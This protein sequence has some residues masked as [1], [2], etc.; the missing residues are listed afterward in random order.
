MKIFSFILAGLVSAICLEAGDIQKKHSEGLTIHEWGTFTSVQGSNGGL[1]AWNPF[2]TDA[3]PSFVYDRTRPLSNDPTDTDADGISRRF[4]AKAQTI[5]LQRMETPVIYAYSDEAMELDVRVGFP[6]GQITEWYP[7]VSG[8]GPTS[9]LNEMVPSTRKS[10]VEWNNIQIEPLSSD[11]EE[12]IPREEDANHY[13]EARAVDANLLTAQK[14]LTKKFQPETERFL[15]YRGVGNFSTPL[16]VRFKSPENLQ[17]QNDGPE[18]IP[19]LLMLE[20]KNGKAA[21]G[22]LPTL[23]KKEKRVVNMIPEKAFMPMPAMVKEVGLALESALVDNGLFAKEAKS[24]VATWKNSWLTESG[25]RILYILPCEW[26]D[27]T[28]PLQV[29]PEPKHLER[30][31]MGRAELIT[32]STE[33]ELQSVYVSYDR[34]EMNSREAAV[35]IAQL[36]LGRF[37]EPALTRLQSLRYQQVS[38]KIAGMKY[39]VQGIVQTSGEGEK[40]AQADSIE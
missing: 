36:G 17:I 7:Q 24:M 32:P 28:L 22:I 15:F 10:F 31:M 38:S 12:R 2:E 23:Q 30:V 26:T 5:W 11:K 3:L 29:K 35:K 6:S 16:S 4:F 18:S 14:G 13:Y 27:K 1:I 9:N 39:G 25:T 34:G 21:F 19:F 20:V 8:F 40:L 37:T 33:S